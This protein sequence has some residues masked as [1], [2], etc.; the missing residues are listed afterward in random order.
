MT[1]L[2]QQAD[3][4]EL[5]GGLRTLAG[6]EHIITEAIHN[7]I[8]ATVPVPVGDHGLAFRRSNGDHTVVDIRQFEDEVRRPTFRSGTHQFVGVMS[9]ARYV[10]RHIDAE[11]TVAYVHDVYGKGISMMTSDTKAAFVVLDDHAADHPTPTAP[12]VGRRAHRAELVLR[13]TAAARRWG[14]VLGGKRLEQDEFLDLVVDGISEIASPDGSTLRDLIGDLH[15]IRSTD[16]KSVM[17]T[18]GEG[19]IEVAEN[20]K[21]HAGPGSA[22]TFPETMTLVLN[23]F[24]AV[25][26]AVTLN[27]RIKPA[28]RDAR[29]VFA[30]TCAELDDALAR[31][32]GS[33][34]DDLTDRTGLATHWVP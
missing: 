21:L 7:G 8:A 19:L 9:L 4:I 30:L 20:V 26:D 27:V 3:D 34:A 25:P 16:I 13:P 5:V 11:T 2:D 14:A 23:P 28:V 12:T 15:A 10:A 33:V 17:R 1:E 31:V 22:V 18:G 32:L 24:A 29:V 6:A